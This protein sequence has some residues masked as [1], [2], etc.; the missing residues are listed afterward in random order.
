MAYIVTAYEHK[1]I[2]LAPKTV[3]EEVLQN[4]AMII[5]TPQFTVP[6][7]RGFGLQQRFLDKPLAVAQA[8]L[9]SEV[10]DAIEK[11][12]PRVEIKNITFKQNEQDAKVGK[13]IPRVEVDII[14]GQ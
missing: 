10:L 8:I 1:K 5:S 2:N 3:I 9:V 13:L 11:Y 14:D 4:V 7:D 6:L 12:E